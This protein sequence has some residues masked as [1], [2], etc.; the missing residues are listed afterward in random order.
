MRILSIES[1]C[2]DTAVNLLQADQNGFEIIQEKKASQI[3]VHKKYGGV[4]PEIAGRK[5]AEKIVPT[6]ESVMQNQ[7]KPDVIAVSR[8]PGLMT[9]LMVGVEAAKTL[10]YLWDKKLV[11]VNHM[12]GHIYSTKIRSSNKKT[13]KSFEFPLLALLVSGGHTELILMTDHGGYEKIGSTVDD[14]AG[15]ALDKVANMLDL[16]YP[17]GPKIEELAQE[18]DKS[19]INFPRPMLDSGDYDFSFSGL[20]TAARYWLEDND[21]A[22]IKTAERPIYGGIASETIGT[23]EELT[24][25]DFCASF[26]QAVIDVL[27]EKSYNAIEEYNPKQFIIAGGVSA[28]ETLRHNLDNKLKQLKVKYRPEVF[29]PLQKY[30]MDNATMIGTAGYYQTKQGN[31]TEWKNLEADPNLSL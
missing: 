30:C 21:L 10:S 8:G 6:I 24:L 4:V 5:H 20:K 26:Q 9:G 16:P 12:E 28:N 23:T 18:G 27:V 19:Q 31:Y 11:G 17:G 2:D 22:V 1:T 15:E 7:E 25:S 13:N 14:A 29:Y 3:E